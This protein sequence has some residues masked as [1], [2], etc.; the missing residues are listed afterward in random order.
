MAAALELYNATG[1]DE[2]L[3]N[4]VAFGSYQVNKKMDSNYPVFS[5]EGI[6]EIIFYSV[7]YL[8]VTSWI[9]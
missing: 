3:R 5:G 7:E 1:E 2:Y 4:A 8:S 6:R 9:W